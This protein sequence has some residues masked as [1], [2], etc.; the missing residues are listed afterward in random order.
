M[1]RKNVKTTN[2]S[3]YSIENNDDNLVVSALS[4]GLTA[5]LALPFVVF[6]ISESEKLHGGIFGFLLGLTAYFA[7]FIL[8]LFTT[9]TS[10][11]GF[12]MGHSSIK[13]FETKRR[14]WA[15]IVTAAN[16][17]ALIGSV[18]GV[19]YFSSIFR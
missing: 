10:L 9:V 2:S 16:F 17:V 14:T 11:V 13:C 15:I 4:L 8:S 7:G 18:I 5:I 6:M 19:I 12:L 1:R 3:L